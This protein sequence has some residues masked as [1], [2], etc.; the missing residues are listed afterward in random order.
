MTFLL[1]RQAEESFD[2]LWD[3]YFER[4]GARL[5]DRILGQMHDAIHR[6][7]EQP[8]LGHFRPDLT[9][10]PLRFYPRVEYFMQLAAAGDAAALRENLDALRT[11]GRAAEKLPSRI[12]VSLTC[13]P[14]CNNGNLR[15]RL[16]TGHGEHQR[17]Q[18]LQKLDVA[19]DF[20][21]Q[22]TDRAVSDSP[23]ANA[24]RIAA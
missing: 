18:Q 11:A 21:R 4:G 24:P 17:S 20:V 16:F 3:Y 23:P 6:L 1:S 22:L 19:H 15:T 9:D 12:R 8:T 2:R 10:K 7:I 14:N 13:C 5:A